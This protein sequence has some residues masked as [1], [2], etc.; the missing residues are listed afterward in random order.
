[1][2]ECTARVRID[3][4]LGHVVALSILLALLASTIAGWPQSPETTLPAL[5]ISLLL[6]VPAHEAV[7]VAA[8]KILGAGRVRV[9]PLIFWRY[10]VVGVAVGFSSPLSLARWSLTALAPL[11]TLSPLFLALSGLGGTWERYSP[12][13]SCSTPLA[14]QGTSCSCCWL[15]APELELG[16][17]TRGEL[18][19]YSGLAQRPGLR[20][21]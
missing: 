14:P 10:L 13:A 7:H 8:A 20:S 9:E 11:V 1:M 4:V 15:L 12:R 5:L 3:L 2:E 6:V 17:W 16:S 21:C 19:G 18:S